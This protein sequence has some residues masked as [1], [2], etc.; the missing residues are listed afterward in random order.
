MTKRVIHPIPVVRGTFEKSCH[1]Y[2][3][4]FGETIQ[5]GYYV[6]YID[7]L[8][9]K[10]V[11]DAGVTSAVLAGTGFPGRGDIQSL[12]EGMGKLGLKPGDIDTV[13]I[14][15]LHS[16]HVALAAKFTNARF[17]VQKRELEAARNPHPVWAPTYRLQKELDSLNYEVIEGD[18][19]IADGLK[20]IYTPGHTPGTQSVAVETVAGTTV[21]A[22]F[23]CIRENFEPRTEAKQARAWSV[24]IPPGAHVDVQ[25]AY[26]SVLRVKQMA[27]LVI[28]IHS[29][30]YLNEKMIP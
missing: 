28:P 17:L 13:I 8:K 1:L 6:W 18:K 20:L 23:C 9:E 21:I 29:P 10:V 15:H 4:G 30:E 19:D 3:A 7:G 5:V 26:D 22:G 16:D 2:L 24:V 14:T 25:Q 27:K 12:E 11:V